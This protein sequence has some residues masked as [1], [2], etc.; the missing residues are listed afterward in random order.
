M[1]DSYCFFTQRHCEISR[2]SL[3]T[4]GRTL[5]KEKNWKARISS[6]S[7]T[8]ISFY[9]GWKLWEEGP[10]HVFDSKAYWNTVYV[11][12]PQLVWLGVSLQITHFAL[13]CDI[14]WSAQ[15]WD[16]FSWGSFIAGLHL[17]EKAS[18]RLNWAND[19]NHAQTFQAVKAYT[20]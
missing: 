16:I 12:L 9:I 1:H 13:L 10:E 15:I 11:K 17:T 6:H 3:E 20:Q 4:E 8:P 2:F 18:C 5:F 14:E 7:N 19:S